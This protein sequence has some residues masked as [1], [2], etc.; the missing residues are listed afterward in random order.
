MPI[1]LFAEPGRVCSWDEFR[2][3]K[4]RFSIALDGFVDEGTSRDLEGPYLNLDHHKHCDRS[5]T[6]ST[7]DQ[8]SLEIN[9]G[10]FDVFQV[11]GL[12]TANIFVNDADEDVCLSVWLL[13]NHDRVK[14]HAEPI[15]NRLIYCED[16][17]D[18]TGGAYP[19][20]DVA[21][22][23]KMAWIFE[24]YYQARADGL[25]EKPS[26]EFMKNVIEGVCGRITTHTLGG[27]EEL[28]LMGHYERLGGGDGWIFVHET[29]AASR[30]AM[31][32]DGI[33]AFVSVMGHK[34]RNHICTIGKISPWV[35]FPIPLIYERLN[36]AEGCRGSDRWGGSDTIGG[37][38]R[39][40]GTALPIPEI[41]R[42]VNEAIVEWKGRR[43]DE[44]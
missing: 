30:Q 9:M 3:E 33:K 7:A 20:G 14:G 25:L 44:R 27:G 32:A 15:I 31:F 28:D 29:G 42:I 22:R 34:D 23:R 35:S 2:Q 10:I 12:P 1:K 11:K 41:E 16:R 21:I 19:F 5:A 6:R 39:K 17:L 8:V 43:E 40:K 18:V 36:E 37:S 13:M 26:A 38:P 4:P 24:P